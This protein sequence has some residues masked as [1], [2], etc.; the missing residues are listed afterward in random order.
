[1]EDL[2]C[3]NCGMAADS[4]MSHKCDTCGAEAKEHDEKHECG[5]E[6]CVV[7]CSGCKEAETKC[8]C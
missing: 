7:K 2:K 3:K 4:P 5:G 1:M 8:S 6:H